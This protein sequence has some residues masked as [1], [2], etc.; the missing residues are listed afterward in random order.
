V[1]DVV[2]IHW[3]QPERCLKTVAAFQGQ[4]VPLRVTVVDN[5]SEP[6]ARAL[7]ARELPYDVELVETGENLGFGP[8]AN[9]GL[10]RW[11]D[12]GET[13]WAVIA[14]HDA[15]PGAGCLRA[16]V[17]AV[18]AR[19]RAGLACADVGDG[20]TPYLDPYFGGIT[21]P[22]GDD[23]A[24]D[25]WQAAD[26][27]HGTLMAVRRACVE[28]IGIFDERYFAYCEEA[29]LGL[30][31]REAGWEV[32]IVRTAEVRNPYL[33]SRAAVVDYLML[34]NTLLLVRTHFGRYKA[35]IRC[36]IALWHI[37]D[38]K[39]RPHREQWIF[40]PRAR[41]RALRDYALGRFGP[42]PAD[43]LGR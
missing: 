38:G 3:N 35:F 22:A 23:V 40:L 30:K 15:L 19:P 14:P 37:A 34:R 36:C 4:D 39:L 43:L 18:G 41:L 5:G 12:R 25:G 2:L 31:A 11:L 13:E 8:G 7:L 28:Q 24:P 16:L 27:P 29:D 10:R 6:G 32:G 21:M 26:Y 42:P 1:L 33:A 17:D 20:H 9:V